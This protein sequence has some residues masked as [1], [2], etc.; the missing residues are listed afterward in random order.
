MGFGRPGP[1]HGLPRPCTAIPN[2]SWV[3]THCIPLSP[4]PNTD[5]NSTWTGFRNFFRSTRSRISEESL[6]YMRKIRAVIRSTI[7]TGPMWN[8]VPYL[9]ILT[10]WAS[11]KNCWAECLILLISSDIQIDSKNPKKLSWNF[12]NFCLIRTLSEMPL[13]GAA[14]HQKSTFFLE[15]IN[16]SLMEP[17][18]KKAKK[19]RRIGSSAVYVSIFSF[20][21][22][23]TRLAI[24]QLV[25]VDKKHP[26]QT[27]FTRPINAPN[28]NAISG[29]L[30]Y[31]TYWPNVVG[32]FLLGIMA[33]QLW[34]KQR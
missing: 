19:K 9:N 16:N 12:I 25:D 4:I 14:V 23:W 33:K 21:G 26:I 20:L 24:N 11:F 10:A 31:S 8:I 18:Q 7:R 17:S 27:F 30:I 28:P 13:E 6:E 15:P 5:C 1:V 34:M 29:T 32:C 2:L 3:H 22:V